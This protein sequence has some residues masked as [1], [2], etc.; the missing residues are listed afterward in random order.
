MEQIKYYV[1]DDKY[2]TD[3]YN[4]LAK[5]LDNL[6]GGFP[7]TESGVELRIL[8]RLFTP[9][10]AWLAMF[11]TLISE[12]S[13]VIA[14]RARI[15]IEEAAKRLTE[16]EKK[17]L[18]YGT[19]KEGS[20]P[21]YMALHFIVGIWEFQLNRLTPELV[22]DVDEYMPYW[23]DA[24]TWKKVPQ[25]RSI[26]VGEAI[27]SQL[28][29]T[30]YEVAEELI[31][32]QDKISVAPCICRTEQ[33]MIGKGCDKPMETCLSFGT[34]ADF[35]ERNGLGRKI[36]KS[37][38]LDIL[39]QANDSGLVLSPGNSQEGNFICACCGCCCGVLR[40]MKTYPKPASIVSSSFVATLN[41]EK[42]INC[43]ICVKRCEMDALHIENKE[44]KLDKDRCIGCGLCVTKCPTKSISLIRKT[45]D[46]LPVVPK[47][48]AI[49]NIK[50]AQERGVLSMGKLMKML[51]KSQLDRFNSPR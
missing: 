39:K 30:S 50:L 8:R 9:E 16:M 24:D 51:V 10:D 35:Y 44:L 32:N 11:L 14:K 25:I 21:K 40:T 20:V 34:A 33:K 46:T 26:P 29:V 48:F 42:C 7:K 38:A 43:G 15:S 41:L 37:E 5:H 6:P 17:G 12:E 18:I 49:T 1:K 19:H 13:H 2:L 22:R 36:S 4:K 27:D 3:L 47:N 28:E 45:K 31:K 23:A